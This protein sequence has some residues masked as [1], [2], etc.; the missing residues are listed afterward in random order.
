MLDYDF[1]DIVIRKLKNVSS[2]NRP[3]LA[4]VLVDRMLGHSSTTTELAKALDMPQATF[5]RRLSAALIEMGRLLRED[6][7][8]GEWLTK[9]GLSTEFVEN[10]IASRFLKG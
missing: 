7:E 4:T 1:E 10:G 8:V 9:N 6:P 3:I 5:Y 2:E